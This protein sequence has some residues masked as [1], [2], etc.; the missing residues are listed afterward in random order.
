MTNKE[1]KRNIIYVIL[2]FHFVFLHLKA[3]MEVLKM[4]LAITK[5]NSVCY[6]NS[7]KNVDTLSGDLLTLTNDLLEIDWFKM[8]FDLYNNSVFEAEKFTSENSPFNSL[9]DFNKWL[10][11]AYSE[12][13]VSEL[14]FNI[15]K[16]FDETKF[17]SEAE[18]TE[19]CKILL[20]LN[21]ADF[22]AEAEKEELLKQLYSS[23]P[24]KKLLS[25][26]K[27]AFNE[28]TDIFEIPAFASNLE[29]LIFEIVKNCYKGDLDEYLKDK[30]H[31]FTS[32]FT[33]TKTKVWENYLQFTELFNNFCKCDI[34]KDLPKE[35]QFKFDA[36]R[37]IL[38]SVFL[39]EKLIKEA[40][41]LN[42]KEDI[43]VFSKLS[44]SDFLGDSSIDSFKYKDYIY[45]LYEAYEIDNISLYQFQ[46][47]AELFNF[48]VIY[49]KAN[50]KTAFTKCNVCNRYFV[51]DN[52]KRSENCPS[53][54]NK[55]IQENNKNDISYI[56]KTL[57]GKM[58]TAK[59]RIINGDKYDDFYN[60]LLTEIYLP[61][62]DEYKKCVDNY[63][64]AVSKAEILSDTANYEEYAKTEKQKQIVSEYLKLRSNDEVD[65]K[66]NRNTIL[67]FYTVYLTPAKFIK[68]FN[69]KEKVN[70]VSKKNMNLEVL[71]AVMK[72]LFESTSGDLLTLKILFKKAIDYRNTL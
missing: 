55:I 32:I 10:L 45:S 6:F 59:S 43:S 36:L 28:L 52:I 14:A 47:I 7:Q 3:V 48:L 9:K 40:K 19:I 69:N 23:Y 68:A 39:R 15:I 16:P 60:H 71:F 64:H 27:E 66:Y 4:Q 61:I 57:Q 31:Y 29:M 38:N 2:R 21:K 18:L 12:N 58:Y 1:K 20:F 70:T 49:S 72:Q 34:E 22:Y 37:E 56:Y 11:G 30:Q 26:K 63:L 54:Q 8:L 44:L 24:A 25:P 67:Q 35:E 13:P 50:N 46:N 42:E 51:K 5:E 33:D 53:C 17:F 41:A 65:L 62:I